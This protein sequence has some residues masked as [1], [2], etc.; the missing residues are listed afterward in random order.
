[1]NKKAIFISVIWII[2]FSII[3]WYS[4]VFAWT[5]LFDNSTKLLFK[6]SENI[7]LDSLKLNN[8]S[9]LFKSWDDLS[10]Y[11]IKSECNIFSKIK[12]KNWDYYMFDVK[13]FDNK[14]NNK[15]FILVNNKN[16][17]ITQFNL[18]FITEV[19]I[20]SKM[21]DLSDI[22]LTQFLN[23]L[24]K[25]INEYNKYSVYNQKIENNYYVFLEKN[26]ILDETIYKRDLINN[27]L[28]KRKNKYII[29]VE[30]KEISTKLNKLPNTWRPYRASYTDWIHHWWDIDANIWDK[31]LA[32]D[33]AIVIRVINNFKYTDLSK[34]NYSKNLTYEDKLWN[35]DILRWN[36]V[37]LKTMKW[38][39]A[40]YSHLNEVYSNIK[41]WTI[42]K[43]WQLI[44]TVW[45]TWVPDK[46]YADPHLH[47]PIHKNPYDNSKAWTYTILDYMKW[48]WYFKWK[49]SSYIL[50][51]Q[52]NVFE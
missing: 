1:M 28:E 34:I 40:F 27:I 46:D 2:L 12:Y 25:K 48:D 15:N 21:L 31:A 11:K 23:V 3:F 38:D 14:C 29:A 50:E 24:N 49:S 6:S 51:N 20:Y 39:V 5:W 7:Y 16:E 32:L 18:N 17:I 45:I 8:T 41:E 10:N 35:L 52:L 19:E 30:W 33:D 4:L 47:M 43:K 42:V 9:V 36:Q 22:R 37:W 26:R 13:F 44:G